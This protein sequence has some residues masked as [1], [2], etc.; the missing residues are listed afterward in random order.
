M[1]N[2]PRNTI[3]YLL[4]M[5]FFSGIFVA[6]IHNTG[7]AVNKNIYVDDSSTTLNPDGSAERPYTSIQYAIDI[8]EEGDTIYIFEGSYNESLLLDKEISLVGLDRDNTTIDKQNI[9]TRY[10]IEITADYV[11]LEDVTLSDSTNHN[12]VALLYSTADHV[13]VEGVNFSKTNTWGMYFTSS[14]DNTI[15][16]NLMNDTKG[17]NL[18]RSVGNVFSNNI[19]KNASE[20]AI[21]L[22]NS[23]DECIVYNNTIMDSQYGVLSN[24]N[25]KINITHNTI[26][27]SSL[28]GVSM[29]GG[30]MHWIANNTV[31]SSKVS[32]LKLGCSNSQVF[33]NE[34]REN[35]IAIHLL[36][37][38]ND[39]Y[40]NVINDSSLVGLETGS[41]SKGNNIYINQFRRNAI[42]AREYG[43]NIWYYYILGNYWDNYNNVDKDLNGIGDEP[44]YILGGAV[45]PYPLGFFLRPPD[46]PTDPSPED[47]AEDVGLSVTLSV[48]VSDV[49]SDYVDVYFYRAS[50]DTLY[51]VDERVPSGGTASTSFTLAFDTTFLWYTIVSDGK[52]ENRSDIWIFITRQIPPVNMKP[53]ADAGGPYI[54]DMND[55]I[56]FDASDSYDPDGT[57][58]FYRWSFG[59]GSSEILDTAPTHSYSDPGIYTVTLTVVD[60]DGRSATTTTEV[61]VL[62]EGNNPPLAVLSDSY[63]GTPGSSI[64]LDATNSYDLDEEGRIVNYSWDFSDGTQAYGE[65]VSHSYTNEGIYQIVLVVTDDYG[66]QASA[67]ALVTIKAQEESTPGFEVL[68]SIL[69][70]GIVLLFFSRRKK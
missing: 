23:C 35:Q 36:G 17:V 30:S 70:I 25:N 38:N 50:D 10:L 39:I 29:N 55:S 6:C 53:V 62:S 1:G 7:A 60:N 40:T 28:S 65:L 16:N 8:A 49:D 26:L 5:L 11:T 46:K 58:D 66:E 12:T 19:F 59:D 68:L 18:Y 48:D 14:N 52:L 54:I 37:S 61:T 67:S 32:G 69:S 27:R 63:S 44:F 34:F 31:T 41:S 2:A 24:Q 42:N 3:V 4:A 43:S 64:L 21:K 20:A 15:G 33:F 13:T 57:L 47:E 9:P 22:S 56:T 45:D 51:G